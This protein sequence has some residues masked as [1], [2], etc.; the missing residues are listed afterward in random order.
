[1]KAVLCKAY[2]P[3][4][5]LAVENLPEPTA[6]PGKVLVRVKAAALNFSDTLIIAG[7][8]Q[9]RPD[10]PFS[11]GAGL[12]GEVLEVEDGVT[13]VKPG[14]RVVAYPRF[15]TC[16]EK[17]VVTEETSSPCQKAF[18]SRSRPEFS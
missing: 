1:M 13:R 9:I 14:D 17:V 10:M 2:G 15:G 4:D 12:A 7:R 18:S 5:R 6:G 11:P 8:Y 16:R 3:P